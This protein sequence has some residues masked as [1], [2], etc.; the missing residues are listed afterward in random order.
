MRGITCTSCHPNTVRLPPGLLQVGRRMFYSDEQGET[1]PASDDEGE[2]EPERV[3][4]EGS[5]GFG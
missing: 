2:E 1:V 3:S 5:W 4:G